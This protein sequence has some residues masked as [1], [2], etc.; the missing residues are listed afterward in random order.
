[1]RALVLGGSGTIGTAIVERLLEEGNEVIIQYFQSD[2]KA[3]QDKH[4][5]EAVEFIQADLTQNIDLKL[6]LLISNI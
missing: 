3:L 5:G 1:M 6:P 4:K 2:L